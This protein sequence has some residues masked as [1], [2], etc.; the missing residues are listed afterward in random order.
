M[1]AVLLLATSLSPI[2][3][4]QNAVSLSE[5]AEA[6]RNNYAY[7]L[8]DISRSGGDQKSKTFEVTFREGK[9]FRKLIRRDGIPVETEAKAHNS[10]HD[11][12]RREM[13][14]EFLNALD[15]TMATDEY[16]NGYDCWVLLAKPKIGYKPPSFRTA[17]LTQMEARVWIAKKSNRMVKMDAVTIGPVSFGGFL[18]KLDP[19]TRVYLEQKPLDSEVWMPTRFK[20]TY[21]GRVLFKGLQGE[22]EQIFTNYRRITPTI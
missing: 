4:V 7:T 13:L 22:I 16:V 9:Q 17:F 2:E 5:K 19:G 18:A 14:R 6:Q 21:N 20:L 12:R 11:E 1:L 15:F 8:E 10:K 3:I